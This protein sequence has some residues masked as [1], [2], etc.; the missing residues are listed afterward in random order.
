VKRTILGE[1]VLCELLP[2]LI[3]RYAYNGVLTRIEIRRKLEKF[4]SEAPFF[5]SA[6]RPLDRVVDDVLEELP[7]PLAGAKRRA[8]QQTIEFV[9]HGPSV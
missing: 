1:V 7:A 9:P 4:H 2:Y 8:F 6:A 3:G 5:E